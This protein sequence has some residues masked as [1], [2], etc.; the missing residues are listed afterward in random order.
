M[1]HPPFVDTVGSKNDT[2]TPR[3]TPRPR[4]VLLHVRAREFARRCRLVDAVAA[5]ALEHGAGLFITLTADR[6]PSLELTAL[7]VVPRWFTTAL[8]SLSARLRRRKGAAFALR[9]CSRN[10]RGEFFVHGHGLVV[11]VSKAALEALA[12]AVGLL[13]HAEAL[14]EPLRAARYILA[15]HQARHFDRAE[16]RSFWA[17]RGMA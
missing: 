3:P 16:G 9:L 13:L 11:G 17:S 7:S 15:A 10:T 12:R 2:P 14:L 1:V 8:A 6:P 5:L 4:R